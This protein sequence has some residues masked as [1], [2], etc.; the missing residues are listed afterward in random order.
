M[1]SRSSPTLR[2]VLWAL[3]GMLTTAADTISQA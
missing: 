1:M 2:Y 3:Q